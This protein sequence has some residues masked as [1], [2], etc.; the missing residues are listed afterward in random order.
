MREKIRENSPAL[1]V[2][3]SIVFNQINRAES[4]VMGQRVSAS[5]CKPRNWNAK[6]CKTRNYNFGWCPCFNF[7]PNDDEKIPINSLWAHLNR[8]KNTMSSTKFFHGCKIPVLNSP[9]KNL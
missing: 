5:Q 1:S 4:I 3:K 8:A 7:N 2:Y 9:K 6:I